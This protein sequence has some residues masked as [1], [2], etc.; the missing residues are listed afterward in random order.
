V[1][2]FNKIDVIGGDTTSSQKVDRSITAIGEADA[3]EISIETE[4]NKQ[5]YWSWEILERHIWDYKCL[6]EKNKLFQV[7]LILNLI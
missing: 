5:I 1:R 3:E 6:N 2:S 7:N 4:Q